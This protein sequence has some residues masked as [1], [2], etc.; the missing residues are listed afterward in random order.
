MRGVLALALPALVL[1]LPRVTEVRDAAL[2]GA[3]ERGDA[4]AVAEWLDLGEDPRLE[5]REEGDFRLCMGGTPFGE[6]ACAVMQRRSLLGCT[7]P[8]TDASYRMAQV[9]ATP[10]LVVRARA[11]RGSGVSRFDEIWFALSVPLREALR[12]PVQGHVY[13]WPTVDREFEATVRVV[14]DRLHIDVDETIADDAGAAVFSEPRRPRAR[15][16][17]VPGGGRPCS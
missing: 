6:S 13:G 10:F 4:R 11:M 7:P 8:M 15:Y 14:G 17:P 2:R 1:A 3:I 12:V 5:T 16:T 9:A